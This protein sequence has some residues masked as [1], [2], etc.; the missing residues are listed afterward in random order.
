MEYV[1]QTPKAYT[2]Q[3]VLKAR[4][5]F[6]EYLIAT[7]SMGPMNVFMAKFITTHYQ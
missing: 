1:K 7:H 4:L 5:N 6:F 2:R 3:N